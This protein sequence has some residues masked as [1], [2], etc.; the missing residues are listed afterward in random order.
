MVAK[1]NVFGIA[2]RGRAI[3]ADPGERAASFASHV[4][5]SCPNVLSGIGHQCG[6]AA[7]GR[8]PPYDIAVFVDDE[9]ASWADG[10]AE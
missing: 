1:A 10:R 4:G 8:V 9:R 5:I 2:F 7:P 3:H 6:C